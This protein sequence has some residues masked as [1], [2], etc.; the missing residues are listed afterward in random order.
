MKLDSHAG[1][2]SFLAAVLLVLFPSAAALQAQPAWWSDPVEPQMISVQG[3]LL[4]PES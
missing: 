3:T 4:N 2:A 1:I